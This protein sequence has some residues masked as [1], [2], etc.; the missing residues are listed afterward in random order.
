MDTSWHRF[1]ERLINFYPPLFG[2][3]IHCRTI[4]EHTTQVEMKLTAF[5]RNI[6]GVHFGGSLYAMCDPWFALI[7]IRALGKDYIVWDKAASIQFLQPGRS[8]VTATFHIPQDRIA[9]IRLEADRGQKIEPTFT[10]DVLDAQS[11]IVAHVEK[12]LYVRKKKNESQF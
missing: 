7:L 1:R 5:N 11:Q 3:G 2:A 10:V 8:S 6:Y 9:E 12:L 4:D